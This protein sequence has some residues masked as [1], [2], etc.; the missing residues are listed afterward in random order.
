MLVA[1]ASLPIIPRMIGY[2]SSLVDEHEAFRVQIVL[3]VKPVLAL[4]NDVW[5]VLRYRVASLFLRVRPWRGK[6][7]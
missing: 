4:V 1:V 3:A 7:R 6:M 5:P 2:R